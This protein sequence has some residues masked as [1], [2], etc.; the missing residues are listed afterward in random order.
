MEKSFLTK[1]LNMTSV[2]V[3][4]VHNLKNFAKF[5]INLWL[6]EIVKLWQRNF[7]R[8]NSIWVELR[9]VSYTHLT[10]PTILRV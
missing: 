2:L 6:L 3:T 9:T 1:G 8:I 5:A 10:L 4:Y 7:F